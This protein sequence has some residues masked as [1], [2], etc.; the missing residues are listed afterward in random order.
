VHAGIYTFCASPD[1]H[2]TLATAANPTFAVMGTLFVEPV[3]SRTVTQELNVDQML[4]L[5]MKLVH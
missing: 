5:G 4:H 3:V 1:I 2:L